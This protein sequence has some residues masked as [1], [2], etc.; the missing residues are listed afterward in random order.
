MS[1]SS[2]DDFEEEVTS[3]DEI[4]RLKAANDRLSRQLFEVKHKQSDYISAL[5]TAAEDAMVRLDIQPVPAPKKGKRKSGGEEVAVALLSDIQ[6]GKVTPDYD[7]Q[8][9]YERVM[10]YAEKIVRL[11]EIQRSDHPVK[12]CRVMALGDMVE[13]CDIFPGQQW[14]IDST[15]YD[16]VCVNG[17]KI[18]IEFFR[19][20]LA[21][22][23]RVECD[24]V[25]GNHGRIG[26]K[27][28]FSARDNMDRFLG[29]FVK[30]AMQNDPRFELRMNPL[31]TESN[32][33]T[34]ASVGEY[35]AML[36][37]GNQIRGSLGMPWY[38]IDKKVSKWHMV[39]PEAFKDVFMGHYHQL[40]RIPLNNTT[41][42]ANGSTESYNTYALENLA[43]MS[44]P[45]QWL[46]FV[47]PLAGRVTASYGV[48]LLD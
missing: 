21:N 18:M 4:A 8:V 42:Y 5:V 25:D 37:H 19:Y 32:W 13:G 6:L 1:G 11:A 23:D 30:T 24:W 41:V 3:G 46:L 9:A 28:Q 34:V 44:D 20:L 31:A 26:R 29:M 48:E 15:L 45:Q 35:R 36:I 43:S 38:G 39:I 33:Y 14:L 22:F 10:R 12:T 27:G 7:S 2:W 40:A 16:Q 17:P 47:D